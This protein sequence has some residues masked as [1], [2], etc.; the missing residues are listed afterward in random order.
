MMASYNCKGIKITGKTCESISE[1]LCFLVTI[2]PYLHPGGVIIGAPSVK[3]GIQSWS[4]GAILRASV[5][6]RRPS[7][8]WERLT[9]HHS[10][11]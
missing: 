1:S 5:L 11:N 2:L 9:C 6:S 10:R 8:P 4:E 7:V 3:S